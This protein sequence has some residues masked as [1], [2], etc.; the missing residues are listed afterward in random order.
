MNNVKMSVR[1]LARLSA[2][3]ES[4]LADPELIAKA[5]AALEKIPSSDVVDRYFNRHTKHM[6]KVRRDRRKRL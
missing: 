6:K 1:T 3:A 4:L 5:I 2:A